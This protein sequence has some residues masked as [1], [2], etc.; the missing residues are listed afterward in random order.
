[1]NGYVGRGCLMKQ[2]QEEEGEDDLSYLPTYLPTYLPDEGPHDGIPGSCQ[3][4][5]ASKDGG[6]LVYV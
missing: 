2:Q 3:L 1:M 5:S 4:G 6:Y